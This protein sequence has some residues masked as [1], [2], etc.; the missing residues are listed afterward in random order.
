MVEASKRTGT[1]RQDVKHATHI[2][3]DGDP[4]TVPVSVTITYWFPRP[5]SHYKTKAGAATTDLKPDRATHTT[6][7][8]DGDIDKLCRATLDGLSQA[9]GGNVLHDDSLVVRL[10]CEKRYVLN[11]ADRPGADITI[12]TC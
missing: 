9:C 1:W 11:G 6:S 4:I 10:S 7:T 2:A 12:A 8:L 5:Q 3:Y